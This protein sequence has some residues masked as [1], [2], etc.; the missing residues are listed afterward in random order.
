MEKTPGREK[1]IELLGVYNSKQQIVQ[2]IDKLQKA[3][4]KASEKAAQLLEKVTAK[5]KAEAAAAAAEA[6]AAAAAKEKSSTFEIIKQDIELLES[7]KPISHH[8]YYNLLDAKKQKKQLKINKD[9]KFDMKNFA[10]NIMQMKINIDIKTI[11]VSDNISIYTEFYDFFKDILKDHRDDEK[12]NIVLYLS[13]SIIIAINLVNFI[14]T[15]YKEFTILKKLIVDGN[16]FFLLLIYIILFKKNSPYTFFQVLL[17]HNIFYKNQSESAKSKIN[18]QITELQ[19]CSFSYSPFET[20]ESI[21]TRVENYNSIDE[22]RNE[23]FKTITNILYT[24]LLNSLIE[25]DTAFFNGIKLISDSPDITMEYPKLITKVF[26]ELKEPFAPF[27]ETKTPTT[28]SYSLVKPLFHL[29]QIKEIESKRIKKKTYKYNGNTTLQINDTEFPI[30]YKKDE[31]GDEDEDEITKASNLIKYNKDVI[32]NIIDIYRKSGKKLYFTDGTELCSVTSEINKGPTSS[33]KFI[34]IYKTSEKYATSVNNI[35]YYIISLAEDIEIKIEHPTLTLLYEKFNNSI[36]DANYNTQIGGFDVFKEQE[37]IFIKLYT[38]VDTAPTPS[39]GGSRKKKQ[40]G[41]AIDYSTDLHPLYD[42]AHTINKCNLELSKN[43]D[44]IGGNIGYFSYKETIDKYYIFKSSEGTLTIKILEKDINNTNDLKILFTNHTLDNNIYIGII[45]IDDERKI[46]DMKLFYCVIDSTDDLS[47]YASTIIKYDTSTLNINR[48]F[49]ISPSGYPLVSLCD[50]THLITCS[51][52]VPS[53]YDINMILHTSIFNKWFSYLSLNKYEDI[54]VDIIKDKDFKSN[55]DKNI[56][57]F[58][59]NQNKSFNNLGTLKDFT[60][61]QNT[62]IPESK[63][64]ILNLNSDFIFKSEDNI[65][66]QHYK[67]H[68]QKYDGDSDFDDIYKN[69]KGDYF[70]EGEDILDLNRIT[71]LKNPTEKQYIVQHFLNLIGQSILHDH[72]KGILLDF[73]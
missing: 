73:A 46:E 24:K 14:L 66:K 32:R 7:N 28:T 40:R 29:S 58:I 23:I 68:F 34:F 9:S 51:P 72:N 33:I 38:D 67:K 22:G 48:C 71:E 57:L 36:T 11:K 6:A 31:D 35:I 30:F 42:K 70:V 16:T 17:E 62:K 26:K 4:E 61:V 56:K 65:L 52:Y 37:E 63:T 60:T 50:S 49:L 10:K 43:I 25:G 47:S 27:D 15:L 39:K 19:K 21:K 20:S 69:I 59:R 18:E 41:G 3:A 8:K 1:V 13:H 45:F 54:F 5:E 64:T 12:N 2:E 55:L 44:I 53:F